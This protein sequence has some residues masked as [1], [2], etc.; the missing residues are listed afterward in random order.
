MVLIHILNYLL[1]LIKQII[2]KRLLFKKAGRL[3]LYQHTLHQALVVVVFAQALSTTSLTF[4][5]VP[6][7]IQLEETL[8]AANLNRLLVKKIVN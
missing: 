4:L 7:L 5:H 3:K 6:L 8:P 1:F 2:P